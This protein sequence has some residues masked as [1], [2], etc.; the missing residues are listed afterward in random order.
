MS[1]ETAYT[2]EVSHNIRAYEELTAVD[3]FLADS[4]FDVVGPIISGKSG[5]SDVSPPL[6]SIDDDV[7]TTA[8][9]I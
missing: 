1:R 9:S 2:T 8:P 3:E 7:S 4:G 5:P 6:I